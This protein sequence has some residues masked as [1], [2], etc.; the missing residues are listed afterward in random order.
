M[1]L[2]TICTN[3]ALFIRPTNQIENV[4]LVNTRKECVLFTEKRAY[5]SFV[6]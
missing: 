1:L 6:H 3:Q 5:V 2:H 4:T